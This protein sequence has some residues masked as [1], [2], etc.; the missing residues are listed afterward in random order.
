VFERVQVNL[1]IAGASD[2]QPALDTTAQRRRQ[3]LFGGAAENGPVRA[4]VVPSGDD[5]ILLDIGTGCSPK[6]AYP[7]RTEWVEASGPAG[8]AATA[9][10]TKSAINLSKLHAWLTMPSTSSD[11]RASTTLWASSLCPT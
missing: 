2:Q 8:D 6:S 9:S 3:P 11:L 5:R 1:E 10:L 7:L 4:T